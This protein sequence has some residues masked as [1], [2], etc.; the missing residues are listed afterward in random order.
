M[1]E[2][3]KVTRNENNNSPKQ[4]MTDENQLNRNR[5]IPKYT[6][7]CCHQQ[8][9]RNGELLK[10]C[11]IVDHQ[12]MDVND[13][14]YSGSPYVLNIL[15]ENGQVTDIP[16]NQVMHDS[17]RE[18]TKYVMDNGLNIYKGDYDQITVNT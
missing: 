11:N 4:H 12:E 10:F 17:P 3:K 14:N 8:G 9:T 5:Y 1:N 6:R 18:C 16:L 15:W 13:K 7:K 2:E